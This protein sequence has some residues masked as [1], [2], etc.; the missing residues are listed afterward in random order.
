MSLFRRLRDAAICLV[1]LALPFFV[2]KANLSDPARMN[3]IDR[4]VLQLS[5]PIQYVA[6]QLANGVSVMLQ[7]Y[8]YLVEVKRDNQ[9]LREEN[10]RLRE[11]NFRLQAAA[12]ENRWLRRLLQ[13]RDQVK[14]TLLS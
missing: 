4:G 3:A 13:L 12:E 11:A 5:A 14:G 6:T 10:A 7:E 1:L 8:V 9:R 2:L